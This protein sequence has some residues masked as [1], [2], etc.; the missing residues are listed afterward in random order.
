MTVLTVNIKVRPQA[1]LRVRIQLALQSA[2]GLIRLGLSGTQCTF[3]VAVNRIID[4]LFTLQQRE[5]VEGQH[6]FV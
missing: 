5:Q 4:F 1:R 2:R 6:F 3:E